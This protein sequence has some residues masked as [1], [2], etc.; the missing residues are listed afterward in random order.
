M[1]KYIL[2]T[3]FILGMLYMSNAQPRGVVNNNPGN[4]RGSSRF[5]WNGEVGRDDKD[6]AKFES[7]EYGF[8]AMAKLITNYFT[9]FNGK[10]APIKSIQ[11]I[12]YKYAPPV[13][14]E[15][16]NYMNFV[17]KRLGVPA[18]VELTREKF[19]AILPDLI[20]TMSAMENGHGK[21]TLSQAQAGVR[22]V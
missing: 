14:N 22:M 4:I 21:F 6:F 5:K 7:V 19:D 10:R 15:S 9:G 16:A 20:H 13:E 3:I 8:R 18:G 11:G 12:I 2:P 1:S 17:S